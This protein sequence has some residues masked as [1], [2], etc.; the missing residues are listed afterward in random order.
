M[1]VSQSN[2]I[3]SHEHL[4]SVFLFL[5]IIQDQIRYILLQIFSVMRKA[6]VV[7]TRLKC[8]I[9]QL[10]VLISMPLTDAGLTQIQL[11]EIYGQGME[12]NVVLSI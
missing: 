4:K 6:I 3:Y 8:V 5:P 1:Y 7:S 9:V 12:S 11:R 2:E 10:L